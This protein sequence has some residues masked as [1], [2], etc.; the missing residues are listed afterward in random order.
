[1]ATEHGLDFRLLGPL[2]VWRGDQRLDIGERRQRLILGMLLLDPSRSVRLDRL[3][4]LAWLHESPPRTARNA[5]QVC[6]SRLRAALGDEA[7]IVHT[8]DG[9]AINVDRASIDLYR[10]RDLTS[11]ARDVDGER[12][13]E[14]LRQAGDLWRGPVL[15]GTFTDDQRHLLC[16]GLDAEQAIAIERRIETELQ[17]G[18]YADAIVELTELMQA[19]PTHER[20]ARLTM[21]SL[22]RDGQASRALDVYRT[23]RDTLAETSGLDPGE[24]LEALEVAVLRRTVDVNAELRLTDPLAAEVS[25]G[26]AEDTQE[27]FVAPAQL[28]PDT[29]AF[30]GRTDAI[31]VL[32]VALRGTPTGGGMVC[33]IVTG[34]GGAGKSTLATH[35]AHLVA[36]A[37]PDGQI[38]VELHGM[39]DSPTR[40]EQVLR[41][42]LQ[43]LGDDLAG[44][45]QTLDEYVARF[46]SLTAGRRMLFVLDDAG[47]AQQ[48]RPLLPGSPTCAVLITSRKRT[49]NVLGA[50][51]V[52]LG[53]LAP[54][55][56]IGLLERIIGADRVRAEPEAA[57]AIVE[58]CGCL[59]LAVWIAG[60]R[61]VTRRHWALDELVERLTDE[62]RRLDELLV[63]DQ[64]VRATIELSYQALD[65]QAQAALRG[66]G[67]L[68]SP[69][70]PLW[71]IGQLLDADLATA[72]RVVERL[73]DAHLVEF[74]H[75]DGVGEVRYRLHDLVRLYAA[76]QSEDKDSDATRAAALGRVVSGW[77]SVI[78]RINETAPTGS[79]QIRPRSA[80]RTPLTEAVAA[81]AARDPRAWFDSEHNSL[82]LGIELAAALDLDDVTV[83]L[84]TA[85]C[86]ST[87]WWRT[88]ARRRSE[89]LAVAL[90]AA[91]RAG[92]R[93]G[94][95]V[96]L[97]ELGQLRCEQD[98]YSDA[99]SLLGLALEIFR[100]I[101]DAR[102]QA[103]TLAELGATCRDQ[104]HL[105][106][107]ADCVEAALAIC[108]ELGD[109]VATAYVGRLAGA[110]YLEQGRFDETAEVLGRVREIYQRLGSRRG[111][112]LALRTQSMLF[113]A[114]GDYATAL[115]LATRA[116][117]MFTEVGDRLLVAYSQRCIGKALVRL[118]SHDRARKPL[119]EAFATCRSLHD[120]WGQAATLRTLGELELDVGRHAEAFTALDTARRLWEEVGQSVFRARTV[121]DLADLACA[122]GDHVTAERWRA[123]AMEAFRQAG[124]R[125]YDEL[126]ADL[127][128]HRV[129]R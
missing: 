109:D 54:A 57:L 102:G 30:T 24:E 86:G 85:V 72:D 84:T 122:Q 14:L 50:T 18:R 22:Y 16:S 33:C 61:L 47:S 45:P 29:Q 115:D 32:E 95:A 62:R 120:R 101:G 52:E 108:R 114:R 3:T 127:E 58:A 124:A 36:D 12:R 23:F 113:R 123:E 68:G 48:I 75:T 39:S 37:F 106:N 7:P 56:A 111:E 74:G 46:R 26:P 69:H 6:M 116:H 1:M 82:M 41:R 99:K 93:S 80:A 28:P 59:P 8:G 55:E 103:A 43:A 20:L 27:L 60:A 79:M 49:V 88:P 51:V 25:E 97:A 42:F 81:R 89:P 94:E 63:G 83:E 119:A 2:E 4:D 5:I 13:V 17:L 77:L 104:G 87:T 92:N 78:D 64:E 67:L 107:A 76:E 65:D 128:A 91:R 21:L 125:E 11:A 100:D 110:I 121:A 105:R 90:Q 44:A 66:L 129:T 70:F 71:V 73:V 9:Y 118:G 98:R 112:A 117:A 40:P 126:T 38:Y 53:V 31:A 15:D 19:F 96:L 10:F 34:P 35:V